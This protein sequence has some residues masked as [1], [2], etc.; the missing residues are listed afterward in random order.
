MADNGG[1]LELGGSSSD[2][3]DESDSGSE[4]SNQSEE[5]KDSGP[6]PKQRKVTKKRKCKYQPAWSARGFSA[7][8]KGPSFVHCDVCGTTFSIAH[9]GIN[10]IKKHIA[11]IKHKDTSKSHTLKDFFQPPTSTALNTSV[12][13]AEVLFA[14]FIAEHNLPF[15]LADHFTRLASVMFTDS[16]IAKGFSSAKTKTTCIVKGALYPHFAEPVIEQCRTGPFTIM[17]DE[18]NDTADKNFAIL[19]RLWDEKLGKPVTRFLDMPVC[20]RGT[21]ANLFGCI[22]AALQSRGIPWGNI[23]GFES[24]T[25]NVMMGKHNSVLSRIKDKQPQVV[26]LGCVCHLA[27]L[28]LVAAVKVLPVDV[29][30]FFVDIFYYFDKSAKRKEGI[31]EFQEF[32]GIEPLKVIKHCQTRWLSL[33]R[34]VTRVLYQWDALHAY[35]DREVETDSSSRVQRLNE[36]LKNPLYKLV[37]NFLEFALD[38]LCKFNATFQLDLPK[39]PALKTEV[40]RLLCVLLGR[41][42]TAECIKQSG[43]NIENISLSS[44]S[45]P[46]CQ[47]PDTCLGI[48]HKARAFIDD[49]TTLLSASM[50][51]T[52]YDGVRIFYITVAT[53]IL[54]KFTFQDN[55]IDDIGILLPENRDIIRPQTALRLARRFAMTVPMPAHD[56]LEEE[57]L[58][59]SLAPITTLPQVE[60]GQDQLCQYWQAIGRMKCV[61]GTHR[62]PNLARLA[63]CMLSLPHSNADT[64]R[65]FSIVRKIVTD[66]R[67]EME[68]DTLCALVA[69]KLNSDFDCYHF[70]PPHKVLVKAK[71]ATSDYNN[72]HCSK[73]T[74]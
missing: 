23:I 3:E 17:C 14:N 34:A 2:F 71:K 18:G 11:T 16:K 19:V 70:D 22:E 67:T 32:V 37:L 45:N 60:E 50:E 43:D 30:D 31:K 33:E 25:A 5:D 1:S 53:K 9:G 63:K 41:F 73:N 10:D 57:V 51:R 61:D 40:R 24:D 48:G 46:D 39:L 59:Y 8:K 68:Q 65:V 35:F 42:M 15:L 21:G 36:K 26:S 74:T 13:K 58:D 28:C 72:A 69:C 29:N 38:S 49:P 55:L 4:D 6:N 27:N 47:M 12:I 64:E 20:N 44:L 56:S 66:Y 62:F 7:S 54:Q 52:F